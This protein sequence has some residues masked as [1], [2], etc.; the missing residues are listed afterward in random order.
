MAMFPEGS[1]E[2][3]RERD[4]PETPAFG[5][6]DV[7]VPVRPANAD[8]PIGEVDVG[9]LQ[10]HHLATPQ[11]GLTAERHEE[12]PSRVDR[13]SRLHIR[14]IPVVVLSAHLEA[15]H[16]AQRMKAAGCLMK[17]V[18]FDVSWFSTSWT[19]RKGEVRDAEAAQDVKLLDCTNHS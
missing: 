15:A 12:V 16:I 11:S 14:R 18:D 10:S 19:V 8:L 7:A 3:F 5:R 2:S 4:T 13:A 1:R 17:P 9:P 6:C